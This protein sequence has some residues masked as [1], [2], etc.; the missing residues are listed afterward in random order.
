MNKQIKKNKI[1]TGRWTRAE[2]DKFMDALEKYGRD[3]HKIQKKIKTRNL[4]QIRS[5]AQKV[6]LNMT[7]S[8]IKAYIGSDQESSFN[9]N[10]TFDMN[11][12]KRNVPQKEA[13]SIT[14]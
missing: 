8:D 7:E 12:E 4:L 9:T 10:E 2:H 11:S 1:N 5:H 14:K 3:W 6:F 13:S